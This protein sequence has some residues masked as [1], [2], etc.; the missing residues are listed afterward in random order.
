MKKFNIHLVSNS[1]ALSE[2]V[3][4]LKTELKIT[5][6]KQHN[7]IELILLNLYEYEEIMI[8]RARKSYGETRYNPR[9]AGYGSII[10]VL[11]ALV[12]HSFIN[13]EL[14]YR[15]L[16]ADGEIDSRRTTISINNH[17]KKFLSENGEWY[18]WDLPIYRKSGKL[19]VDHLQPETIILRKNN[20]DK[21]LVDYK[22]N[23]WTIKA[24]EQLAEYND[25]LCDTHI[26]VPSYDDTDFYETFGEEATRKFIY[27]EKKDSFTQGGRLTGSWCNLR[28][29]D[30][31]HLLINGE[32][33]IEKDFQASSINTLYLHKTGCSFQDGDPYELSI[34]GELISR[35]I[36][37]KLSNFIL[38]TS[39]KKSLKLALENYSSK[40]KT[41]N[42]DYKKI[43]DLIGIDRLIDE[44]VSKHSLIK[45]YFF[46]GREH[47]LYIQFLESERVMNVVNELTKKDIPVLTV[48]DSFIVPISHEQ[49][50]SNAMR[51]FS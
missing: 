10:T 41:F 9:N 16:G 33:T 30:R 14:G 6:T 31:H 29:V 38:F 43:K 18:E 47:G 25:I 34:D 36:V 3:D 2:G 49:D 35:E 15:K 11:D 22:D 50:L 12:E 28:K 26:E 4:A 27:S 8:S 5:S 32:E 42:V 37:K 40:E 17:L 39:S 7:A 20:T 51:Q 21:T 45:D 48:Y 13:Q 19:K 23:S 24:R 46:G 44:F 1:P